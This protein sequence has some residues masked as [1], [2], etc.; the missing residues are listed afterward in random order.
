[1]KKDRIEEIKRLFMERGPV[2]RTVVLREHK[3]SS[4]DIASLSADALLE[5]VKR[6]YYRWND[7]QDDLE[8]VQAI[9]PQGVISVFSAAVIH[10][11]TTINPMSISITLPTNIF[12]PNLPDY[13]PVEIFRAAEEIMELGVEDYTVGNNK[14]RLYNKERT[15]C[16][17]FKYRARMGSDMAMEVLKAYMSGSNC[18]LQKLI[19]YAVRLRVRKYIK[20]YVEALIQ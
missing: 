17:F 4:R 10:E 13:P 5:K 12:K 7:D 14:I 9:F 11:L 2:L 6:G 3:I 8:L 16:D 15:V 18:D 20:P 1:M 19:E